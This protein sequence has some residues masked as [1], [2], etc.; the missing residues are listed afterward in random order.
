MLPGKFRGEAKKCPPGKANGCDVDGRVGLAHAEADTDGV[1]KERG[2][3]SPIMAGPSRRPAGVRIGARIQVHCRIFQIHTTMSKF[4]FIHYGL[5][6]RLTRHY[7]S[8]L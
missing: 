1:G 2:P 5:R 6:D 7:D 8:R 3:R 4:F